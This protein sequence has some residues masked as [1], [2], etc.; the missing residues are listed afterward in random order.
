MIEQIPGLDAEI[1]WTRG[2]LRVKAEVFSSIPQANIG[3]FYDGIQNELIELLQSRLSK[4]VT[5][6]KLSKDFSVYDYYNAYPEIRFEILSCMEKATYYPNIKEGNKFKGVA[7]LFLFGKDGIIAIF[8]KNLQRKSVTNYI[9]ETK[10]LEYFDT[11]VVDVLAFKNFSPSLATRIYDEDGLLLYGPETIEYEN[12]IKNGPCLYTRSLAYAFSSP[13]TGKRIFYTM[14]KR[15]TGELNTDIVL[16]NSDAAKLFANRRSIN[17]IN[18][19][20]VI[21]VKP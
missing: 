17:Y 11:L 20:N 18:Q 16:F 3:R 1:D 5:F 19:G 10:D 7:E 2:I 12:F 4:A 13:R 8:F 15:I 9:I 14:P 21:I 6:V